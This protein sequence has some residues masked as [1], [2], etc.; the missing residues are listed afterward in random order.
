M[1]EDLERIFEKHL[2]VKEMVSTSD[3]QTFGI[4]LQGQEEAIAEI[5]QLIQER[6]EDQLIFVSKMLGLETVAKEHLKE[7]VD[8]RLKNLRNNPNE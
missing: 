2:V 4:E 7:M 5:N 8:N 6:V 3:G 1:I